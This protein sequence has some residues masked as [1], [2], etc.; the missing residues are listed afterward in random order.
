MGFVVEHF[1]YASPVKELQKQF[2]NAVFQAAAWPPESR[3]EIRSD[4]LKK[5]SLKIT[6]GVEYWMDLAYD[7]GDGIYAIH[8]PVWCVPGTLRTEDDDPSVPF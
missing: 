2:N 6:C 3:I 8:I 4:P 5:L 7:C 1:D